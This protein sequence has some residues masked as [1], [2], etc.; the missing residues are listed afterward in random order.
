MFLTTSGA[1]FR[2]NNNKYFVILEELNT[3]FLHSTIMFSNKNDRLH[4]KNNY[5]NI[6]TNINMKM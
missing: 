5:Y 2:P 1:V 6:N 4:K 3:S